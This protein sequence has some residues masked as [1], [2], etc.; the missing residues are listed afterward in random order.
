MPF[1]THLLEM[2]KF[3]G[4]LLTHPIKR[5]KFLTFFDSPG[6][7]AGASRTLGDSPIKVLEFPIS[8]S[9]RTSVSSGARCN[10]R[11][12]KQARANQS[13]QLRRKIPR[14]LAFP[15]ILGSA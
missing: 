7:H 8:F 1:V 5:R 12:A 3:Q 9:T 15:G 13:K 4:F 14:I 6:P 11:C 2:L 10:F